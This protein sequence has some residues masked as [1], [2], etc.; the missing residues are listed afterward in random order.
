M[1]IAE[2]SKNNS[3]R[4]DFFFESYL[5]LPIARSYRIKSTKNII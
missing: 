4:N 5:A 1:V 2:L 3:A